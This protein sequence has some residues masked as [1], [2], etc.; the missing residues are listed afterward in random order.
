[1]KTIPANLSSYATSP[2][3][4]EDTIPENLLKS[5]RTKA[6]T[7]AKIIVLEGRLKYRI[8]EPVL[9]EFDLS[10]GNY[11]VVEPEVPHHVEADGNVRFYLEFYH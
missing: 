5:H 6:R 10:P 11:G 3:F 1:M 8:S 2:E 4:T 7:W 9:T